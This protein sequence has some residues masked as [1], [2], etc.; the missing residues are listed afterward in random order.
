MTSDLN[1][2]GFG[3]LVLTDSGPGGAPVGV[4]FFRGGAG[5]LEDPAAGTFVARPTFPVPT[6]GDVDGDGVMDLVTSEGPT[7]ALFAGGPA[8][9]ASAPVQ[10]VS[11]AAQAGT[12]QLGDFD[13]DG[14]FD[15]AATTATTTSNMFFTDDRID[16]YRSGPVGLA[17]APARTLLE[18]DVLPDNQLNFGSGLDNADFDG[19]GREDLLVGAPPPFPTPYF[20]TSASAVF[21]Y[22]GSDR[23]V[24]RRPAVRLDGA[25]GFGIDISAGAP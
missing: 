14:D 5:G 6:S 18:T 19:D 12:L 24:N 7:F 23:L 20:D 9:P 4:R 21:V 25:P 13:G 3:D 10:V 17:T 1:G 16:L 2:D 22:E 11:L 8:F 15:L